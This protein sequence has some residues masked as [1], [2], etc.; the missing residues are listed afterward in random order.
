MRETI[1]DWTKTKER[2]LKFDLPHQ[3]GHIASTLGRIRAQIQLDLPPNE[4]LATVQE[5]LHFTE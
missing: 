5:G 2:Y 3:L 1:R 4:I